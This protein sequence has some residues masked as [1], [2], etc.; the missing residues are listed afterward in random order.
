MDS[1]VRKRTDMNF[2]MHFATSAASFILVICRRFAVKTA[3]GICSKCEIDANRMGFVSL[4]FE[5]QDGHP[6]N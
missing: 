6:E 1:I 3:V 2:F 5:S 4:T